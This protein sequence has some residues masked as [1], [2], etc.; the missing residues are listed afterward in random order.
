MADKIAARQIATLGRLCGILPGFQDNLGRRHRTSLATY[1]ALLSAMGVPWENPEARQMEIE[2][3]QVEGFDR[4]LQPVTAAFSA[5]SIAVRIKSANPPP[6][7]ELKA[8]VELTSEGG[9]SLEGECLLNHPLRP[10]FYPVSRG[11]RV[12]MQLR[13]PQELEPGYYDLKVRIHS[14]TGE[15]A[16]ATRLIVSPAVAYQP[17]HLAGGRRLWGFNLPLYALT[18]AHNWGIGDFTDLEE[19][20]R[21]AGKLGAAFVGVNPLHAPPPLAQ[22][23]VSPYSPTSR[24][25]LNFLYLNLEQVPELE[26][27][28]EAQA[29]LASPGFQAAKERVR[30]TPLVAYAEIFRLKRQILEVLFG[31]FCAKHG[32]EKPCTVRGQEFVRFIREAGEPLQKFAEFSALAEY[33]EES[34]WRRWP[35]EFHHP[36]GEAVASF[37]Q[38]HRR[39]LLFHQYVQW[40]ADRHLHGAKEQA[41]SSGLSFTLYQDLALGTVPGGFETWVY[42]G[43]FAQG[44]S[45]GAPP[46]AFNP[47]GQDWG[48]PPMIP[49]RLKELRFQPFINLLRANLP[50][51]GMLRLDHVMALFRLFWIPHT[52]QKAAGAY[53]RYPAQEL[54]AILTLESQRRR[55]MI[56]GE[57]LGTVAPGIR[58]ELKKRGIFS[59]R[60]FY[61]ERDQD[62]KFRA[63]GDYP[64][65]AVAA[66]TTHDLPTLAGFWEG[67]D[68]QVKKALHLYPQEELAEKDARERELDRRN[69]L[70]ALARTGLLSQDLLAKELSGQSCPE[71]VRL[72]VL[73]Y[74]GQSAAALVEIRLEDVFGVTEQQNLPGTTTEYPNWKLKLPLSLI[75]MREAPQPQLLAERMSR[76]GRRLGPPK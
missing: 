7:P 75:Q 13:L 25:F 48:L 6:L 36:D 37:A 54:L 67:R 9:Q 16:D 31:T 35:P 51:D 21:W 20:I 60:V 39:E 49:E 2:R 61:F 19:V 46:D 24:Q 74:L 63:P 72:G 17:P 30:A 76:C 52:G 3:R 58:R 43:L 11:F 64:R 15:E 73:E 10:Q 23:S 44:A 69:L 66:V 12:L 1:Q 22:E 42:P 65:Q 8:R 26:E 27:S 45:V 29:L 68:I 28:L 59:Y 53:V 33:W 38:E 32:A 5:D 70:E 14:D 18:S 41:N 56:I 50:V 34:D 4:L 47:K 57:D 62:G 55:T 71:E 40:L